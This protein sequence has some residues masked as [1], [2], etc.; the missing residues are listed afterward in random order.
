[1]TP[2]YWKKGPDCRYPC[3]STLPISCTVQNDSG[4][5]ICIMGDFIHGWSWSF[6][7]HR[8]MDFHFVHCWPPSSGRWYLLSSGTTLGGYG[9]NIVMCGYG[10][11]IVMFCNEKAYMNLKVYT[12]QRVWNKYFF[13]LRQIRSSCT[14]WAPFSKK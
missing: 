6:A 14:Q 10:F 1:M 4:C 13:V 11:N 8:Q 9:F 7:S 5:G 2:N 12:P 3:D